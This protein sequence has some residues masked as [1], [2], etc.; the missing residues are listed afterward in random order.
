MIP[1][2]VYMPFLAGG[3]ATAGETQVYLTEAEAIHYVFPDMDSAHVETRVL[4]PVE[5]RRIEERLGWKLDQDT[6]RV[7]LGYKQTH[8]D[9]Y[10][11]ITDQVGM[12]RPIT[13]IVKVNPSGAISN[14]AIMTYRESRGSEVRQKR[15]LSQFFGK[16]VSHHLRL[17]RDIDSVTGATMSSRAIVAGTKRALVIIDE[18]YLYKQ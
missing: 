6:I 8:L 16:T 3:V 17:N 12:Y 13:F 2:L 14:M 5:K 18:L 11:M 4:S 15:F 10:A 1:L 7:F 9:G